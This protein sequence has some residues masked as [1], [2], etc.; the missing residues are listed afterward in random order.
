MLSILA[1]Q[2]HLAGLDEVRAVQIDQKEVNG[3]AQGIVKDVVRQLRTRK[4][5]E[6]KALWLARGLGGWK[7]ELQKRFVTTSVH[8]YPVS[9]KVHVDLRQ[10][11]DERV[12]EFVT[13]GMVRGIFHSDWKGRPTG[14]KVN[15]D[16]VI[17]LNS[18]KSVSEIKKEA[19]G[20]LFKELVSVLRHELV[21]MKDVISAPKST[22]A[23][24]TLGTADLANQD[25]YNDPMEVRAFMR[26]IADEVIEYAHNLGKEDP[27]WLVL[28]RHFVDNA[29]DASKTWNR[30]EQHIN[31]KTE[32]KL[33]QGAAAALRAEW[34]KLKKLYPE[35]PEDVEYKR[36][37]PLRLPEAGMDYKKI[38][39]NSSMAEQQRLAGIPVTEAERAPSGAHARM[40]KAE[41]KEMQALL[42]KHGYDPKHAKALQK[43]GLGSYELEDRLKHKPGSVGSLEYTHG[44]KKAK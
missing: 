29:L 31:R 21:H 28:N 43:E 4:G 9:V 37:A 22:K 13:G 7:I 30:V 15:T 11:E 34:P 1:E 39:G 3:L 33:R 40:M 35:D 44:I 2:Q 19:R 32:K 20:K 42:K 23:G 18:N 14:K 25:Y 38:I 8:G 41:L 27:W 16:L 6:D 17:H 24:E 5:D 26:Q 12:R 36:K 10:M